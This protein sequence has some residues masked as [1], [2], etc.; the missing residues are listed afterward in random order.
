MAIAPWAVKMDQILGCD[1]YPSG[2]DRAILPAWDYPPGP[3]RKIPP[4]L[5][6]NKSFIDHWSLF[7]QDAWILEFCEFMDLDIVLVL[8]HAKKEPG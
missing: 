8:K 6:Y 3:E 4:F 2:W 5:P 1:G 7:G